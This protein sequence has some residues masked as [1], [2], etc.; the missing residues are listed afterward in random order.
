MAPPP[1]HTPVLSH[2]L[3]LPIFNKMNGKR[4]ILASASPRRKEILEVLG[5]APE[6]VPSTFEENLPQSSYADDLSQYPVATA[7]EKAME[8]YQRLVES[9]PED[10]PDLVIGAD[11]VVLFPPL[12]DPYAQK[13]L[14]KDS[15]ESV[16]FEKPDNP[17]D[18]LRMLLQISG[19]TVQ[20]VTAVTIVFPSLIGPG[21]TLRS[22]TSSTLVSFHPFSLA[23]A[24]AYVDSGEGEG[25]AGGFGIQGLGGLL[26]E[27]IEGEHNNVV[28][29]PASGF[30]RWLEDLLEEEEDLLNI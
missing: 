30:F 12:D 27:K 9:T 1:T 4:I 8:V 26:I 28:G 3:P 7:G 13:E 22:F 2:A 11:T 18:N 23:A 15:L 21:Y 24:E 20:V 5:F 29:F 10:A 17:G 16:I 19:K 14:G 25:K 6:I